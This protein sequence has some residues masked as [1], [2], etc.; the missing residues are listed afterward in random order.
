MSWV[1]A[2]GVPWDRT[3]HPHTKY[4]LWYLTVF[5]Y[6]TMWYLRS[7][8][9]KSSYKNS[10]G[11]GIKWQFKKFFTIRT[12]I[13]WAAAPGMWQSPPHLRFSDASRSGCEIILAKLPFPRKVG[14]GDFWHPFWLWLLGD[15]VIFSQV[16]VAVI[17][18]CQPNCKFCR[19]EHYA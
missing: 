19:L 17:K 5:C 10:P 1:P 9:C 11:A 8:C 4:T 6:T 12:V 3:L 13:H 15:S 2:C 14:A 7:M 18:I 16:F